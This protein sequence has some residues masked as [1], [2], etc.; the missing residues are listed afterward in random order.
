LD[1]IGGCGH[2]GY[3]EDGQPRREPSAEHHERVGGKAVWQHLTGVR[4]L[5]AGDAISGD[6][7]AAKRRVSAAEV[8]ALNRWTLVESREGIEALAQAPSPLPL[9]MT[10][11]VA[12][13]LQQER[14]ASGSAKSA[15]PHADPPIPGVPSLEAMTRAA[16]NALDDAPDGF[17]LFV[18]GGAVD[19]AM[20]DN[21][22]GRTIEEM[23]DFLRS[24]DAV[25]EWAERHGGWEETLVVVTADHDHML[26]GPNADRVP[27]DPLRD[28]GAGR[29]PAH[30]WLSQSH[31]A[32][33]VPV[34]ARGKGSEALRDHATRTDPVRGPYVDQADLFRAIAGALGG[35]R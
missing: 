5:H 13:T 25:T 8:A 27:F 14:A 32:A 20:H 6:E 3:D 28:E 11:R 19:W 24:V 34:A 10:P 35:E 15:L 18:E 2:P 26:W 33:L 16:L 29:L 4:K 31:S 12:E 1:L 21:Q 7:H 22:L 23:Q 30:R 17:L 9:L